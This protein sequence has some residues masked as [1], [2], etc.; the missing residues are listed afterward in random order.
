MNPRVR[1]ALRDAPGAVAI[2]SLLVLCVVIDSFSIRAWRAAL[3]LLVGLPYVIFYGAY[4]RVRPFIRTRPR[5][6]LITLLE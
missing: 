2:E 5:S 1:R 6:P 3:L 4:G